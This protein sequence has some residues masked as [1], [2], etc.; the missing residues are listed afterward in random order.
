MLQLVVACGECFAIAFAR[1]FRCSMCAIGPIHEYS[2]Q[3]YLYISCTSC[4]CLSAYVFGKAWRLSGKTSDRGIIRLERI[5]SCDSIC[6]SI[7]VARRANGLER[8]LQCST[9][10]GVQWSQRKLANTSSDV[11]SGGG[12]LSC[13]CEQGNRSK[14]TNQKDVIVI[15][16]EQK[17]CQNACI[18]NNPNGWK[19]R[20][21]YVGCTSKNASDCASASCTEDFV[22]L[23]QIFRDWQNPWGIIRTRP[24]KLGHLKK[25]DCSQ[26]RLQRQSVEQFAPKCTGIG[27]D[28]DNVINCVV[29]GEEIYG[30]ICNE[31][32]HLCH[33]GCLTRNRLN[34]V[35]ESS[36]NMS[37]FNALTFITWCIFIACPSVEQQLVVHGCS[38]GFVTWVTLVGVPM[39]VEGFNM[40]EKRVKQKSWQRLYTQVLHRKYG[41]GDVKWSAML[42]SYWRVGRCVK[43]IEVFVKKTRK[44]K[45]RNKTVIGKKIVTVDENNA[46]SDTVRYKKGNAGQ[47]TLHVRQF[48]NSEEMLGAMKAPPDK[49][50]TRNNH[51]ILEDA[52]F[53]VPTTGADHGLENLDAKTASENT[54]WVTK[55]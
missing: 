24:S 9:A 13:V 14:S 41:F 44:A 28:Y 10:V 30:K 50:S 51:V 46:S 12:L 5:M 8:M 49:K 33:L 38:L 19:G 55:R 29:C 23:C 39:R 1:S 6:N 15:G 32:G 16:V 31:S 4:F 52:T 17:R 37:Q 54:S 11:G 36:R 20:N 2:F 48:C 7:G 34:Y 21:N 40:Y 3:L 43:Q 35:V 47:G 42:A 27:M 26:K 18:E 25:N 22:E 45:V 53:I